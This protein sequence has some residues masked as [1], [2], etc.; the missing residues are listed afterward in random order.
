MSTPP[1]VDTQPAPADDLSAALR[2]RLEQLLVAVV[3]Q[4]RAHTDSPF[5]ANEFAL[6]DLLLDA[7]ADFLHT[8][9]AQKK[10]AT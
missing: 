6:R 5:G 9:L 7:G 8:A 3:A 1:L 2:P 10:T 4:L